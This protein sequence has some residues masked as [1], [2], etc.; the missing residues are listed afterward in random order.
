MSMYL[1]S[2][3]G[4]LLLTG[5]TLM[6]RALVSDRSRGRRRCPKCFYP[7]E[8]GEF[9]CSE[10]GH[11]ASGTRHL[12]RTCRHWR[13][14][15]ALAALVILPGIVVAA[16]ARVEQVGGMAAVPGPALT[17]AMK[18]G[19]KLDLSDDIMKA[20]RDETTLR[21]RAGQVRSWSARQLLGMA[22]EDMRSED[23]DSRSHGFKLMQELTYNGAIRER[24]MPDHP[25][26]TLAAVNADL[27]TA[28]LSS[29]I[30]T[31]Q[32]SGEVTDALRL[33]RDLQREHDRALFTIVDQID[34]EDEQVG[35]LAYY[36][37][38]G[39]FPIRDRRRTSQARRSTGLASSQ[40]VRIARA[41]WDDKTALV[42]QLEASLLQ[43]TTSSSSD[44]VLAAAL[45]SRSD[46]YGKLSLNLVISLLDE[47]NHRVRH[48]AIKLLGEFPWS[49]ELG[50]A[51]RGKITSN[52]S[53]QAIALDVALD[54]GAE[55]H[56]LIPAI[57]DYASSPSRWQRSNVANLVS[58]TSSHLASSYPGET[59][60]PTSRLVV[61]ALA[62]GV[63]P[64]QLHDALLT[65][66]SG[67]VASDQV[68]LSGD[69]FAIAELGLEDAEAAEVLGPCL[70]VWDLASLAY[71]SAVGDY[72]K[73]TRALLHFHPDA[74]PV[75][76]IRESSG[77]VIVGEPLRELMRRGWA[78]D[79]VLAEHFFSSADPERRDAFVLF[80]NHPPY[81]E[82][83]WG[84]AQLEPYREFLETAVE[85]TDARD[86]REAA[87][88]CLEILSSSSDGG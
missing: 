25:A 1:Y 13:R 85:E 67:V 44:T 47:S 50:D 10:C 51:L 41:H 15:F 49:T 26:V 55:A 56:M 59:S 57:L 4:V 6:I 88:G 2:L 27:A 74:P 72:E 77:R 34:H 83:K 62:M 78:D 28:T 45:L 22:A 8:V 24:D 29:Y 63:D 73:A 54:Y 69:L 37:I 40:T 36:V 16:W 84:A 3:A 14:A 87:L 58:I 31:A 17:T 30:R 12:H 75:D 66:V 82:P 71:A 39:Q 86:V 11:L 9:R 81:T 65:R 70:E 68:D 46:S 79:S 61:G 33:L 60:L 80:L 42:A 64:R 21:L 7:V 32:T 53:D 38:V 35:R 23:L 5:A 18:L 20:I 76:Q 48:A 52:S 19:R 43:E